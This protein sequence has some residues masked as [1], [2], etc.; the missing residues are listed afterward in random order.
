ME[1]MIKKMRA[2]WIVVAEDRRACGE[3]SEATEAEIGEAVKAAIATG[4]ADSITCWARW[5]GDLAATT[6]ALKAIA[7]GIDAR[8]R[9]QARNHRDSMKKA[10]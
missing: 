2:D 9:E 5:L 3:W 1:S 6:I 4:K 8:M 10:A 7:V